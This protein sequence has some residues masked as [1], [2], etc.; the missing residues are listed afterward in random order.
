MQAVKTKGITPV[1]AFFIMLS[2]FPVAGAICALYFHS[3]TAFYESLTAVTVAA[4][5]GPIAILLLFAL[6][7]WLRSRMLGFVHWS[8]VGLFSGTIILRTL[9][10]IG[11]VVMAAIVIYLVNWAVI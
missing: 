8:R 10:A 3:I 7:Q 5:T 6:V 11:V 2:A 1:R 4:V 9:L